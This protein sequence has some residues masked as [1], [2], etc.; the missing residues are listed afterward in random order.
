MIHAAGLSEVGLS[1]ICGRK[2]ECLE[3]KAWIFFMRSGQLNLKQKKY[4]EVDD[5]TIVKLAVSAFTFYY[6]LL[7]T[8]NLLVLLY[9]EMPYS[10]YFA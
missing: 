3:L 7:E 9:I 6:V 1:E 10:Y 2:H 4:N 5:E 8:V